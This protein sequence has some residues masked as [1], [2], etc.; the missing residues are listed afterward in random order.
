MFIFVYEIVVF[1]TETNK[2]RGNS[3]TNT[4]NEIKNMEEKNINNKRINSCEGV[5]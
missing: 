4:T 5:Q 1:V 3:L 2:L